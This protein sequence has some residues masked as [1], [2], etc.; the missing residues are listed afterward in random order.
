[1]KRAA[2][3]VGAMALVL[4]GASLAAQAKAN[5]AGKWVC[6]DCPAPGGGG[7]G[8]GGGMGGGGLGP[9][10]TA[11]QD[12]TTLSI[13]RTMGENTV[14]LKYNLDGSESKNT[15]MGRGG[16]AQELVSKAVWQGASLV[17][18]T[19]VGQGE[20]KQVLSMK[21]GNLVVETTNPG[22]QGGA[23]TTTTQTYKKG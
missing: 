11:A 8:R 2:A 7:G 10:F 21:D 15:M 12:A 16:Q 3:V 17:I 9:E 14:T 20:R 6:T 22:R 18:T 23:P 13:T 19:T 1:M 5:F 4:A